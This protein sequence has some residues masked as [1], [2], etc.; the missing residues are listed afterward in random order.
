MDGASDKSVGIDQV[1]VAPRTTVVAATMN[2]NVFLALPWQ[3]TTN[4][5]TAFSVSSLMDRRRMTAALNWGDAYVCHS[6]NTCADLFLGT[7][8]EWML[9]IDDDVV[10]PGSPVW[11][12]AN[13]R[14][15]LPEKFAGMNVLDRLLSHKKSLVGGLYFGKHPYGKPMYSEGAAIPSEEDYAHTAPID[16]VKPTRWVA[17][18]CLLIHR[19][20]Y[21]DIEKRFPRLA[22]KAD[23]KGGN[24]F[25]PSED[26]A[27]EWIDKC[28][29]ELSS[30]PL[31]GE[32]ALKVYQML[33][34]A[35]N[36]ARRD[37]CLGMGED[38]AFS[39]RAAK[40]GHQPHV[41][42]GLV[43]GHVGYQVYGPGNTSRRK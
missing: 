20:V 39:V 3:K 16:L 35:S 43:L 32:K 9:T 23:G 41:D 19:T 8:C 38:V 33:E 22:R 24:W 13:T 28:R 34:Q 1:S 7:E 36:E 27:L 21:L 42:M 26:S 2:K 18:G 25:T 17:T 14:F 12:N 10:L 15:N 40:S 4:P 11:F 5:L 31:N 6:R 29:I 30:S 37:S